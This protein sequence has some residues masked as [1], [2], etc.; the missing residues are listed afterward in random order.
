MPSDFI[1]P[2][3]YLIIGLFFGELSLG[4]RPLTPSPAG[5]GLGYILAVSTWPVILILAATR[6]S[7]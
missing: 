5:R 3:I 7:K 6:G 1:I 2:I 4:V